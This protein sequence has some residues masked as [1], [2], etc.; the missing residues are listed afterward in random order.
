LFLSPA[1]LAH[2]GDQVFELERLADVFAAPTCALDLELHRDSPAGRGPSWRMISLRKLLRGV[3]RLDA[4][5]SGMKD[6]GDDHVGGPAR[7]RPAPE[8]RWQRFDLDA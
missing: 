2:R 5:I 6:V 8:R 1:Q 3:D 7:C 4:S